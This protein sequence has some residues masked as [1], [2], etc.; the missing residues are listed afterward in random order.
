MFDAVVHADVT[1]VER[2]GPIAFVKDP[3]DVIRDEET[4]CRR[5]VVR[6]AHCGIQLAK[7][8]PSPRAGEY[9]CV[10]DVRMNRDLSA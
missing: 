10:I 8:N 2:V 3:R 6:R 1:E 5:E 7:R 4:K 9:S